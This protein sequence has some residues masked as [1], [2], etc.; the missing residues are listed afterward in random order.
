MLT[1]VI[2]VSGI[3]FLVC[4]YGFFIERN[5]KRDHDYKAACDLSDKVSC[6]KT[7]LSP[8]SKLFGISN[9]YIGMLFYASM[10]LLGWQ[11][12]A[13]L[14]FLGAVG[15]CIASLFFAYILYTKIKTFCLVCT[16]IYV[17]N[18]ILLILAYYN[19]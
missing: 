4:V 7:F 16:S 8:W 5:L 18:L 13:H 19:L 15:A 9:I 11:S 14:V 17:I 12:Q 6:T 10:M 1:E 2:L 3:G